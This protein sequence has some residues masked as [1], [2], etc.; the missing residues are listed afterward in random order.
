LVYQYRSNV[1][2]LKGD[3]AAAID[4]L[5]KALALEP[6]NALFRTNLRRLK[7]QAAKN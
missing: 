1:A 2:Y 7:G 4:A 6:D 5:E 3:T